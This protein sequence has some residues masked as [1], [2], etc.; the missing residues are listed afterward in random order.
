MARNAHKLLRNPISHA[1][2]CVTHSVIRG[3]DSRKAPPGCLATAGGALGST[4]GIR[5]V[6]EVI[7]GEAGET[8]E[9]GLWAEVFDEGPASGHVRVL[10]A[11]EVDVEG[12][13]EAELSDA[14]LLGLAAE[15]A[16]EA[17]AGRELAGPGLDEVALRRA[18]R[19]ALRAETAELLR[20]EGAIA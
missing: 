9:L 8:T 5:P 19:R 15:D 2:L 14:E 1:S 4:E 10:E 6:F 17:R 20:T 12:Y 13:G 7:A 16:V 11:F 3:V 18:R